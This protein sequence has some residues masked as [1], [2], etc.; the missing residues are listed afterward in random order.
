[1]SAADR[2][3]LTLKA[4]E[5]GRV[6]EAGSSRTAGLWADVLQQVPFFA[7]ISKRQ[8]RKIA[9]LGVIARFDTGAPIV[10]AGD[11]G[12]ALYVVLTGRVSVRRGRGRAALEIGPG[13]YFGEMA[14]VDGAPRS[15]TFVAKSETIC[16]VL[17]RKPF[18]RIMKDEP[19]VAFALLRTL[20]ARVRELEASPAD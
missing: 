19:A 2:T 16:L 3:A 5:A 15:A 1:M 20:A 14:L 17:G 11:P 13:A 18:A 8:I 7:G 6:A 10:T 12:E 9:G 4:R